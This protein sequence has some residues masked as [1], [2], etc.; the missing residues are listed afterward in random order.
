MQPHDLQCL[1]SPLLL[2]LWT[3]LGTAQ[4]ATRRLRLLP[5]PSSSIC[6]RR[7]CRPVKHGTCD[8]L[9]LCQVEVAEGVLTRRAPVRQ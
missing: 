5:V 3:R 1:R 7:K 8:D 2:H 9:D 6:G 4:R